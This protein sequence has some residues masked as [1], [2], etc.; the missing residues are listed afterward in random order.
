MNCIEH[1]YTYID[2][3]AGCTAALLYMQFV[4]KAIAGN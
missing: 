2:C 1:I 3:K 4:F